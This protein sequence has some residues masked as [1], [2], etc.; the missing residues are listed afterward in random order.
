MLHRTEDPT[1]RAE[2]IADHLQTEHEKELALKN[3]PPYSGWPRF[4]LETYER[5]LEELIYVN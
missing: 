3:Q 1:I 4:W 2:H 5:V